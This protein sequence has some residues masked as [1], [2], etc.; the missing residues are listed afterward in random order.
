M[1]S[2]LFDEILRSAQDKFCRETMNRDRIYLA[3]RHDSF[4]SWFKPLRTGI[5]PGR[6]AVTRQTESRQ[7]LGEDQEKL[8][9]YNKLMGRHNSQASGVLPYE[10]REDELL[11][12]QYANG[13]EIAFQELYRRYRA[14]AYGYLSRRVRNSGVADELF[15]KVFLKLHRSRE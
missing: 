10:E 6:R 4:S 1:A 12:V 11:M 5:R 14:R 8:C 7:S 9:K 13:D 15:Q 3:F 2:C